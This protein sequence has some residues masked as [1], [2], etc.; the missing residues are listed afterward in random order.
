MGLAALWERCQ[1][2]VVSHLV[3]RG[4]DVK[5]QVKDTIPKSAESGLIQ[6]PIPLLFH[7]GSPRL[8]NVL[9]KERHKAIIG[10]RVA[11]FLARG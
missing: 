4:E 11:E 6:E 1:S 7:R 8:F 10:E 3:T 5:K 9:P 2:V